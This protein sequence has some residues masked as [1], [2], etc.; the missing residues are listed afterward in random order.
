MTPNE[1]YQVVIEV[2]GG[3]AEVTSCPTCVEVTI[4]DHDVE[5]EDLTPRNDCA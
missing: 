1:K 4:I 3:I 5:E 2:T